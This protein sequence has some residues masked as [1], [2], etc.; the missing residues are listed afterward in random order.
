MC[1]LASRMVGFSQ[2]EPF[3]LSEPSLSRRRVVILGDSIVRDLQDYFT[4][5]DIDYELEVLCFPG[6][7]VR[8]LRNRIR[9]LYPHYES[10]TSDVIIHV[11]TNNLAHSCWEI[12]EPR[13][14]N[15][16]NTIR[17]IFRGARISFSCIL[18]RWDCQ[19]L[20]DLSVI[21]NNELHTLCRNLN[22]STID[23]TE[24]FVDSDDLFTKDFVHLNKVGKAVFAYL[25]DA[26]LIHA[27]HLNNSP[28]SLTK[29][30]LNVYIPP[31]LK[32]LHPKRRKCLK[33]P[34]QNKSVVRKVHQVPRG[35][36]RNRRKVKKPRNAGGGYQYPRKTAAIPPPPELPPN[37]HIPEKILAWMPYISSNDPRSS[38]GGLDNLPAQRKLYVREKL[39]AKRHRQRKHQAV[40]RRKRKKAKDYNYLEHTT[41]LCQYSAVGDLP[42]SPLQVPV[43]PSCP[44]DQSDLHPDAP[45]PDH[46]QAVK[47]SQSVPTATY[48]SDHVTSRGLFPAPVPS[49]GLPSEPVQ[50]TDHPPDM[51]H[52]RVHVDTPE[53]LPSTGLPSEKVPS[54]GRPPDI[55]HVTTSDPVPSI[56]IPSEPLQSTDRPPDMAHVATSDL[57][58]SVG[59][60]PEPVQ[61]ADRP[62]DM[63][64]TSSVCNVQIT[65]ISLSL[66]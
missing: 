45:T 19:H 63:V 25:L 2:P 37:R 30:T 6:A 24:D 39:K 59:I 18:P 23:L 14:L 29:R 32:I 65:N 10:S 47:A 3:A 40:R 50:L 58:Q 42:H 56:G 15:L 22:L 16:F 53:P 33:K 1:R 61:S 38:K 4:H 11:G 43:L 34:I 9:E 31:E 12:E 26:H 36:T 49:M 27:V 64:L 5:L 57:F 46:P 52:V 7:T 55:V 41:V 28:S 48:A 62:P 54:S 8:S 20:H 66:G 60:P 51:A 44:S 13:F 21:Y 17:E 35:N